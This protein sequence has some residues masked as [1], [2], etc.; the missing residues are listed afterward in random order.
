MSDSVCNPMGDKMCINCIEKDL[1]Y[2]EDAKSLY[3][4]NCHKC[5]KKHELALTYG[6]FLEVLSG[7]I[8]EQS[9]IDIC[10]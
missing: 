7:K 5:K 8:A 9:I 2:N 10:E 3:W 4:L 6:L 1:E